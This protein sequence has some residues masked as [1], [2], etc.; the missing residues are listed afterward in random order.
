MANDD[1]WILGI[2]MTKFGKHRDK[3]ILDLAS[4]AALAAL[5]DGGVTMKDVGVLAVGN[6][7]NANASVGQQ[8]QKQIGQTGIPVYNVTN[9]C[10]TGATALRTAIMSIKAGETSV[11]MAVGV[12]KLSGAGL[13]GVS[14][15]REQTDTWTPSGREGAVLGLD[16]RVGT[17]NM[18]GVFAQIGMEYGHR[19]GGTSFE[20]FAKIAEKN[21]AHSTLNPLAAY[22]KRFTLEEIMGDVMIA[23]PNTRPMCSA[24][25]DGAAAAIVV[26]GEYLKTLSAQQQRRAVKV[27]ASVLTSDP[28]REGCQILPDVN[29]LTRRAA[30]QAYDQAG[31]SPQDLDLVELHDCFA[32]AELVHYD[33]LMLCEEGNAADF[34]S[35]GATWRDGTTPVNVSGG[36]ESK[37]HPIAATGIANIWEVCHH[38]RGEA[39][40]RQIADA[41]VG[42]A[43]VIGLGSA[44][45][46]HILERS[47]A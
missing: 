29:T 9:A 14:A 46:I 22:Q 1:I 16:G 31:V 8:L 47:A 19:Y 18:P 4:E 38:L 10:A 25:C 13:L 12:E 35:S 44:C 34:F 23:Y 26:S 6:L 20:L 39:G 15:P 28:Y 5:A 40:D 42:L 41:T 24:N 33:N 11:G 3:D 36:L 45:G 7:M 17:E 30:L 32:T 27:S 43:H 37:G 2:T 21:H